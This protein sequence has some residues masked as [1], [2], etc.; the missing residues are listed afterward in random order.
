ME[1]FSIRS[2]CGALL[3]R[4]VAD[5]E[6]S[7]RL[8]SGDAGTMP[9]ASAQE[10]SGFSAAMLAQQLSTEVAHSSLP[11]NAPP[12]KLQEAVQKTLVEPLD[13]VN[14]VFEALGLANRSQ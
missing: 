12:T 8:D 2:L 5:E 3:C 10:D 7:R 9:T 6:N 4:Q 1:L 11:D 14:Q 13:A